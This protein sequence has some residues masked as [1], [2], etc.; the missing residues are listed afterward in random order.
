[1]KDYYLLIGLNQKEVKI[2]NIDEN[3]K[4]IIEVEIENK[5]KKVRKYTK[6]QTYLLTQ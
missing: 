2:L 3:A 4:G 5:N 1:M 6:I